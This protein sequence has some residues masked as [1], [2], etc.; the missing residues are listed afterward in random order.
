VDV[1]PGSPSWGQAIHNDNTSTTQIANVRAHTGWLGSPL[2]PRTRIYDASLFDVSKTLLPN[3]GFEFGPGGWTSHNVNLS[4][5][6]T[7]NVFAGNYSLHSS[8]MVS[9]SP[10]VYS[11]YVTSPAISLPTSTIYT[12]CFAVKSSQIREFGVQL[13]NGTMQT[14]VSGPTWN[15]RVVTFQAAAGS[16][17]IKFYVGRESSDIWFDAVY[18]FAGNADV[19]RRDFQ[20]GSILVNATPFNRT[21]ATNGTFRRIKGTQDPINDGSLVGAQLTLPPYDAAILLRV[22]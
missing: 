2:G 17:T 19:F 11:A 1:V 20:S 12:L 8:P 21:I 4:L 15:S 5:G 7:G 10:D 18:L 16:N 13:G 22:P 3:G 9:Y 6:T 14:L